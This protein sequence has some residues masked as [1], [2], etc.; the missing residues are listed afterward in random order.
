M[1]INSEPFFPKDKDK[2]CLEKSKKQQ[3]AKEKDKENKIDLK[4]IQPKNVEITKEIK[5]NV[6]KSPLNYDEDYYNTLNKLKNINLKEIK[7]FIPKRYKLISKESNN[8]NDNF[9]KK[10]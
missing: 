10:I 6:Q 9:N 7:E 8:S 3:L 1:N 2:N 4:D 5:E